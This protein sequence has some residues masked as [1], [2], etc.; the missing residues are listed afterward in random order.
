VF[1]SKVFPA[2]FEVFSGAA[3]LYLIVNNPFPL[4]NCVPVAIGWNILRAASLSNPPDPPPPPPPGAPPG[5]TGIVTFGILGLGLGLGDGLGLT[6]GLILTDGLLYKEGLGL[7]D[8]DG[9]GLGLT[10]GLLDG[11]TL[12]DLDGLTLG[13]LDGLT[14]GL[15]DIIDAETDLEMDGETLTTEDA[16]REDKLYGD[17]DGEV[18]VYCCLGGVN[19]FIFGDGDGGGDTDTV[20]AVNACDNGV[21]N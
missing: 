12:G 21:V 14:D 5:M 4:S 18:Y 7:L 13:D 10:L 20:A 1:L 8:G 17:F 2:R 16:Y 19:F 11:L 6:L 9:L 3:T 15:F